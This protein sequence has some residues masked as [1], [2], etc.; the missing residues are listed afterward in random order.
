MGSHLWRAVSMT[1]YIPFIPLATSSLILPTYVSI[2]TLR[3]NARL[4]EPET[5]N[6]GTCS[7]TFP[8]PFPEA[9]IYRESGT[10]SSFCRIAFLHE[11]ESAFSLGLGSDV[12]RLATVQYRMHPLHLQLLYVLSILLCHRGSRLIYDVRYCKGKIPR[13]CR[14]LCF[15]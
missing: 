7:F 11:R 15:A 13:A 14:L 12:T 3:I 6:H 1:F 10:R 2:I 8:F 5:E 4:E 9:H